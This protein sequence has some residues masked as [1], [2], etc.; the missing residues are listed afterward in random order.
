[1][2]CTAEPQYCR[3]RDLLGQQPGSKVVETLLHSA[4]L[5]YTIVPSP[6]NRASVAVEDPSGET[7]TAEELVVRL[8]CMHTCNSQSLQECCCNQGGSIV[9]S[10]Q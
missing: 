1:M 7:F 9:S 3:A 4:K 2:V 6:G 10:S 5:P 8:H